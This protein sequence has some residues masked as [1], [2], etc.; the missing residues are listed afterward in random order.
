MVALD[1]QELL[2][3]LTQIEFLWNYANWN[4]LVEW[5]ITH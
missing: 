3:D 4:E 5:M 2:D 1:Q